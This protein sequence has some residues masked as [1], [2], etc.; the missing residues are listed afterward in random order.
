MCAREFH[1]NRTLKEV[2]DQMTGAF[3]I[4]NYGKE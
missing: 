2:G 1:K 3:V 4:L